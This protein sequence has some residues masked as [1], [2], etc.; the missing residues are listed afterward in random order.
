MDL[1]SVTLTDLTALCRELG[2]IGP[3]TWLAKGEPAGVGNMNRTLRVALDG[4][5]PAEPASLVLKQSLPFVARFP[6][7]AAPVERGRIEA[8]FYQGISSDA[9]LRAHTPE[10]LGFHAEHHLLCL[11]DLGSGRDLTLLYDSSTA[12][13]HLDQALQALTR[14]LGKLHEL[15]TPVDFPGNIAMRELNH[16]HIFEVPFDA[17]AAVPVAPELAQL[18]SA[19]A[20]D[21][22]FM[23]NVEYLG[24]IYLG[25]D[26]FASRPVLLHG[27]YYPGSWLQSAAGQIAIIDPEFGFVGPAEFDV[28]VMQA[29]LTF[30]DYPAPKRAE[31]L[32]GYQAQSRFDTGLMEQFA[33]IEV[34]RRLLGVAQLP[35]G[36]PTGRQLEW[37]QSASERLGAR[38]G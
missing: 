23:Q 35:L 14:W 28:G 36:A 22:T 12:A 38:C 8:A 11:Q 7:I 9:Q 26:T 6:E 30:A 21:S 19:L 29:H 10:L 1:A 2:W 20:A 17:A 31:V 32:K 15:P 37:A 27:D 18:R 5:G 33:A 16:E 13:E 24:A 3:D 25:K 34:L 4:R